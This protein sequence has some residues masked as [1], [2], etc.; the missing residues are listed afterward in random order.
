MSATIIDL[1]QMDRQILGGSAQE[2]VKAAQ[3]GRPGAADPTEEGKA[4]ARSQY[5]EG[6][7]TAAFDTYRMAIGVLHGRLA[8]LAE[9]EFRRLFGTAADQSLRMASRRR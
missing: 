5:R 9:L 7:Q 3:A 4:L 2:L 8:E 1:D 6:K